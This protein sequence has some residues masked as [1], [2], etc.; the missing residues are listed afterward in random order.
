MEARQSLATLVKGENFDLDRSEDLGNRINLAGKAKEGLYQ[1]LY[2]TTWGLI[3]TRNGTRLMTDAVLLPLNKLLPTE[4]KVKL[5]KIALS[6]KDPQAAQTAFHRVLGELWPEPKAVTPSLSPKMASAGPGC[7]DNAGSDAPPVREVTRLPVREADPVL[8]ESREIETRTVPDG[9]ALVSVSSA[10]SDAEP[11][12]KHWARRALGA[13]FNVAAGVGMGAAVRVSTLALTGGSVVAAI[14]AGAA[15][16]G[17]LSVGR[18]HMDN[19]RARKAEEPQA[20]GWA[21]HREVFAQ[22][23][24]SYLS[25]FLTSAAVFAGAGAVGYAYG[26]QIAGWVSDKMDSVAALF[27]SAA[28]ET[29]AQAPVVPGV[30]PDPVAPVPSL[31]PVSV[32]E[33][34][35]SQASLPEAPAVPAASPEAVVEGSPIVESPIAPLAPEPVVPDLSG[36]AVSREELLGQAREAL[37]G[38]SSSGEV[39]D[40]LR[41]AVSENARVSAQGIKDLADAV[42]SKNPALALNLAEEALK[43][44]PNNAQ[45]AL[46]AA[47]YETHGIGGTPVDLGEAYEKSAQVQASPYADRPRKEQAEKLLDYLTKTLGFRPS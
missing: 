34:V 32:P 22:N 10:D 6:E 43:V 23:R 39:Q 25:R 30:V 4:G 40:A 16:S 3:L 45:A 46:F 26:E 5:L 14:G 15:F 19:V 41:R 12:K 9:K 38:R 42:A 27:H 33:P 20:Q 1:Q 8:S 44:N 11:Q 21:L 28:G 29:A 24:K 7:P 18:V 2:E 35:V 36:P 37:A 47:Y 31:A 17:A 13:L